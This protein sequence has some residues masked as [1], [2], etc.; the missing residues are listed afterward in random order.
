MSKMSQYIAKD[1]IGAKLKKDH[2]N[3]LVAGTPV[4]LVHRRSYLDRPRFLGG[5]LR[6]EYEASCALT[7]LAHVRMILTDKELVE[8]APA[9]ENSRFQG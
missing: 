7:G 8:F 1:K 2:L 5:S 9:E 6:H 4:S 3:G